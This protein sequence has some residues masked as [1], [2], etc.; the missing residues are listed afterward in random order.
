MSIPVYY[1]EV[2]VKDNG[3]YHGA[4]AIRGPKGEKGD[5]G[6]KGDT[7]EQGA[8]L[9]ISGAA[10]PL[11]AAS[12]HDGEVWV[13]TFLP[14]YHAYLSDGTD[15][16]DIGTLQGPQGEQGVKGDTGDPPSLNEYANITVS[17]TTG[18]PSALC[19][20]E[21]VG[22]GYTFN[23]SFEGIKG[24]K[25]DKGD[26]GD[27]FTYADFTV[28]QLEALRGPRGYKGETGAQGP[29]GVGVGT[30]Y[31]TP[32]VLISNT[33]PINPVNNLLLVENNEDVTTGF[34]HVGYSTDKPSSNPDGSNLKKG[35][36]YVM[37]GN[38][39]N[40]PLLWGNIYVYPI[41]VW[42]YSGSAW[43][44]KSGRMY[45]NNQWYPLNSVWFIDN[46]VFVGSYTNNNAIIN[47]SGN[48]VYIRA[49]GSNYP[50]FTFGQPITE[51]IKLHID[52]T[53]EAYQSGDVTS[54]I[55]GL[56]VHYP[57]TGPNDYTG[58]QV[59]GGTYTNFVTT[60]L[61]PSNQAVGFRIHNQ[62]KM[63]IRNLWY[64]IL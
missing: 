17:N 46:G 43:V 1:S 57:V 51:N 60:V 40:H 15:W 56:A 53:I 30:F 49:D 52:G 2:F 6:D 61:S 42:M 16:I 12:D 41:R 14:P 11:P 48:S 33:T 29:Q 58:D 37:Q 39:N 47:K 50:Y 54:N 5:K 7:G 45:V 18:T 32:L 25:G 55:I 19:F 31:Y 62:S 63:T 10:D 22:N 59:Y 27:A 34:V 44:A 35:D 21:P 20:V 8:G 24:E 9:M 3:T 64:E 38:V 4:L 26:T 28:E 23:F 13:Q 36:V